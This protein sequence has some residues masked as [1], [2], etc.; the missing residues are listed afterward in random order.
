MAP[1]PPRPLTDGAAEY[2]ALSERL[3]LLRGMDF[4][5]H[6]HPAVVL[7]R[8]TSPSTLVWG[9]WADVRPA[10]PCILWA[11]ER[12]WSVTVVEAGALD[13]EGYERAFWSHR[14]TLLDLALAN[15]I[16]PFPTLE[17]LEL[18]V[19]ADGSFGLGPWAC[20]LREAVLWGIG[21]LQAV[22]ASRHRGRGTEPY[23]G[24]TGG[25]CSVDQELSLHG[26]AP[27]NV[28]SRRSVESAQEAG[29][30]ALLRAVRRTDTRLSDVAAG[31]RRSAR[32]GG[33]RGGR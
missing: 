9:W 30:E 18:N 17:Q 16:G 11:S 21:Q 10:I 31:T 5:Q 12:G 13:S 8:A 29:L 4:E 24:P 28:K 22:Q 23:P 33:S 26:L 14:I 3:K 1:P 15:A 6:G 19:A 7:D 32:P 20:E 2:L 25:P 27:T